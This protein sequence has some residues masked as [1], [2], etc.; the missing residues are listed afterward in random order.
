MKDCTDCKIV[1][2]HT[3]SLI[4]V[5]KSIDPKNIGGGVSQLR[6]VIKVLDDLEVHNERVG[7]TAADGK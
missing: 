3:Q 6:S 1:R 2:A 5:L 4:Q 7:K